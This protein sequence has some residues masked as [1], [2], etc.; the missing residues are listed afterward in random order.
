[1][2]QLQCAWGAITGSFGLEMFGA[3]LCAQEPLYRNHTRTDKRAQDSPSKAACN[4]PTFQCCKMKALVH[5]P[6]EKPQDDSKHYPQ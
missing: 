2:N 3:N 4:I 6:D 5:K 1:M